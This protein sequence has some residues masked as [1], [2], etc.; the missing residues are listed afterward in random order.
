[1]LNLAIQEVTANPLALCSCAEHCSEGG[2][3]P[4]FAESDLR[5]KLAN[6]Q[7]TSKYKAHNKDIGY[8]R[9]VLRTSN[10]A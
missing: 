4:S 2:G 1:V 10:K 9:S 8:N 3:A 6:E 5:G 7:A